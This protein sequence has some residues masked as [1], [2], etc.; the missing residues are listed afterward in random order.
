[1]GGAAPAAAAATLDPPAAAS[2][3]ARRSDRIRASFLKRVSRVKENER[4]CRDRGPLFTRRCVA[5]RV[6]PDPAGLPGFFET[7]GRAPG[8]HARCSRP[9]RMRSVEALASLAL[10]F[11]AFAPAGAGSDPAPAVFAPV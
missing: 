11:A 10:L 7:A 2:A 6:L 9:A 3:T 8:W 5:S 4:R 1:M